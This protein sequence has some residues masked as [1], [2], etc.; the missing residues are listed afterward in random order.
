M[1]KWTRRSLVLGSATL[2]VPALALGAGKLWCQINI[3]QRAQL[4][5]LS[6]L[7]AMYTDADAAAAL[8][9]G[10]CAKPLQPRSA[11]L[12]DCKRMSGC[13]VPPRQ[14]VRS[15]RCRLPSRHAVTIFAPGAFIASMAGSW[16]RPSSTWQRCSRSHR[17][18]LLG[19]STHV[20][21]KSCERLTRALSATATAGKARALALQSTQQSVL[22]C[23]NRSRNIRVLR[24]LSDWPVTTSYMTIHQ[25]RHGSD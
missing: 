9:N 3:A 16:R 22:C 18:D 20:N 2:A 11:R 19:I 8:G 25:C 24:Y 6:P 7:M 12:S 23:R 1:N 21:L 15:K 14:G 10:I 4:R 13:D 5:T 17:I